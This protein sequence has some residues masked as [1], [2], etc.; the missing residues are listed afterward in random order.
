VCGGA[1]ACVAQAAELNNNVCKALVEPIDPGRVIKGAREATGMATQMICMAL[2]TANALG[3]QEPV[4][5]A[6]INLATKTAVRPSP[7]AW[8]RC[9]LS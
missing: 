8:F 3:G 2:V 4:L 7:R 5:A 6:Q 1:C 9:S